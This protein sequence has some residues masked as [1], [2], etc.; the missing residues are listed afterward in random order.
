MGVVHS[1]K[2]W[3]LVLTG[4]K[5]SVWCYFELQDDLPA[6]IKTLV[7]ISSRARSSWWSRDGG[8]CFR[9]WGERSPSLN[10]EVGTLGG[11]RSLGNGRKFIRAVHQLDKVITAIQYRPL[12]MASILCFYSLD[13][14]YCVLLDIGVVGEMSKF[15]GK[16]NTLARRLL[17]SMILFWKVFC[18]SNWEISFIIVSHLYG[19]MLSHHGYIC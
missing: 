7:R 6:F 4:M 12:V 3:A 1:V 16:P 15:I 9:W 13:T 18:S 19:I 2:R 5:E 14:R 10:G 8:K 11:K 17:L